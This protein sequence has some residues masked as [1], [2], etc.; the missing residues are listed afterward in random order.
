MLSALGHI[1]YCQ[2]RRHKLRLVLTTLGIALGVAVFFGIRTANI[3]LLASLGVTIEKAAGKATLQIS[4]GES[5]FPEEVLD[6]VRATPG[7]HVAEPIIEVVAHTAFP[8]EGNVLI[9]GVDIA[10]DHELRDYQF[11]RAS[12][13]LSDPLSFLAQ[14]NSILISRTFAD[15]H[16]LKTGDTL[17]LFTSIGRKE[18]TVQGIFKPTGVGEIFGGNIAV[19]DVYSAEV[20]FDRGRHFDR[21]DLMNAQDVS[22]ADLQKRLQ[23]QLPAGIE[24]LQPQ[25]RSQMLENTVTAMRTGMLITSFVA[26]FVGIY[27]I[28]NSFT[29]SVNQRWK[30]IGILRAVGVERGSVSRLF[31]MEAFVMG[32]FGSILGIVAGY[33]MAAAASRIMG[34][35]AADV[36]GTLSVPQAVLFRKDYALV[37]FT[38]G[39]IA[40]VLGAWLPARAASRLDPIL[41]LHNI[42]TQRQENVFGWVRT[43]MGAVL[44][45]GSVLL[46]VLTP[47]RVGMKSQFFYAILMLIGLSIVLPI[48]VQWSARA[49]RPV[50]DAIGSSEGTLA[51]DAMIQAP[52][53]SSATVGAL[54]IG[55]MFVFS[56]GAYI[57]SYR[58]MIDRWVD[59]MINTD[60]IVATTQQLR[61]STYHFSEELGKQISALPEVRRLLNVRFT[62]IPFRGD[63]AALAAIE[64]DGFLARSKESLT[65]V[66]DRLFVEKLEK[67]EAFFVSRNFA[68][69]WSVSVGNE[70]TLQSPTGELRRPVVGIVDDFR[71]EKGSV[72]MDRALYK[73]Y[74]QDN[75]VDFFDIALKADAD[76]DAAKKDIVRI[77]SGTVHAFVYTNA[78]F[79][80]WISGLVDQFFVMNYMQL[81]VAV[82]VSMLGIVNTLIISIS[83]RKR[84]IGIIRALGGYRSQIRKL[85]LLEAVSISLVGVFTGALAA[86]LSTHFMVHTVSMVL[87]GYSVPF[88]FPWRMI[89]LSV[90]IVV[91]GSL[92][93]AW[94]PAEHAVNRQVIEAIG[95]E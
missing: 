52:R 48:V 72:F 47:S 29:I 40:S 19:M 12:S 75:G 87:A 57:Q 94:W 59:S 67:G 89:L 84:E 24:V 25:T 37:S 51:V 58:L 21:I 82:L 7:V 95:Y 10:G 38:V 73:K 85:V 3:T 11:D 32:I 45:V 36:Y 62:S 53:R 78:E 43:V 34:N 88:Y 5:G 33:Y 90:P 6:K 81:V 8:D 79:R 83:E 93:A 50:M 56:T 35:V 30:E 60:I 22:V 15:R 41:A 4:S 54:M 1:T 86:I 31:L 77:T 42:E 55:L 20:V 27:I 91:V 80:K 2:W 14:P 66:K 65:G 71:S 74:W 9:L 49:L 63:T 18:F 76:R 64:M 69:R 44:I 70:L 28:F 16:F 92:L 61:S 26:L 23:A 17:P 39:V 68:S 13:E 46:I